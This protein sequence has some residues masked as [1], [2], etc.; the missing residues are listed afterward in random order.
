M[1]DFKIPAFGESRYF[2]TKTNNKARAYVIEEA[3]CESFD[4][5]CKLLSEHGFLK[6]EARIWNITHL[7]FPKW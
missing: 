7:S 5:Y 1:Q 6:K 4:A 2:D 3:T